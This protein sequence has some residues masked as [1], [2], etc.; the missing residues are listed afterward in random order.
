MADV[1][2]D[3]WYVHISQTR[4]RANLRNQTDEPVIRMQRGRYGQ[5]EYAKR[6]KFS[7]GVILQ[8]PYGKPLLPC[9]ARLVIECDEKPEVLE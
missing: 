3:K 7:K 4:L 1:S 8:A 6:L 9:G 5:P 2:R